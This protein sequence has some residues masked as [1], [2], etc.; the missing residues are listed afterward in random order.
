MRD[1]R[2]QAEQEFREARRRLQDET[3]VS[4][5]ALK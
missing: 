5:A 2:D 1:A 4:R 3:E